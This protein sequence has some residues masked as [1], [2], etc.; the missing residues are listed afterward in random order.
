MEVYFDISKAKG[1]IAKSIKQYGFSP[2]HNYHNYLYMQHGNNRCCFFDFGQNRGV[3]ALFNKS[4]K[5]WRV[6]NGVFA[7]EK[8]RL[9]IF[10]AFVEWALEEN[11]SKKVFAEFQT[12]FRNEIFG[13]LRKIYK[14]IES[15]SLYW[16]MYS[17]DTLDEKLIGKDW[18][19]LRNIKNRF[20][21]QF[22]VQIKDSR[23]VKKEVLKKI[24][25]S[26]MK[27][28][29]PRDRVMNYYYHNLIDSKFMGFDVLR[30]ITLNG[31]VC[32]FSGGWK[33]PNSNTFYYAIGIFNYEHK[34]IGDF[35]NLDD[36]MHIKRL[37]YKY[38]DL[39]GSDKS[40]IAFKKKFNPIKIYQTHFFS[41]SRKN[42]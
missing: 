40:T 12:E 41:I 34:N 14:L 19:K 25:L 37:G 11:K 5:T 42:L 17:L 16:P 3:V 32:A 22:K 10:L 23:K 24:L 2:E 9:G 20:L 7:P 31:K 28:R 26:W 35:V 29:F 36:L 15:Y 4:N 38:V 8:E 6:I 21:T 39:G 27:K 13:K 33:I 1:R 18:K 30:S